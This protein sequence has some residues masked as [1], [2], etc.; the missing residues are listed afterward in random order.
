MNIY[1]IKYFHKNINEK[2]NNSK[3]N[4]PATHTFHDQM[5]RLRR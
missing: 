4:Q 3:S 5:H 2:A 1:K